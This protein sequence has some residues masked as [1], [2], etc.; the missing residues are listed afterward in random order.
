MPWLKTW[1]NSLPCTVPLLSDNGRA[2]K[3]LVV[4]NSWDVCE[5]VDKILLMN[6]YSTI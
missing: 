5:R 3:G 2:I 6:R 1:R 4:C